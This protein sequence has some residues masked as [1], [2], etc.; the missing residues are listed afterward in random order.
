MRDAMS[1]RQLT[2]PTHWRRAVSV[3]SAIIRRDGDVLVVRNTGKDGSADR[4]S[5]PGGSVHAGE[6]LTEALQREV[7]EETGLVV[8]ELGSLVIYSEH[9]I[10]A[11]VE[12]MV[13]STF[14]VAVWGGEVRFQDD[15]DAEVCECSFV[16]SG[17]AAELIEQS[18][19]FAPVCAP[20]AAYLRGE[21]RRSWFW[22][23]D[24][25]GSGSD[26]P[27]AAL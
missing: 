14:E 23:I 19:S 8:Q 4:W 26:A 27:V 11:F 10:P 16:P 6:L 15:P 22:R 7:H 21:P 24:E 17:A 25:N 5:L 12:P 9:Y 2:T 18:T 1:D 3:V 20:V 13:M